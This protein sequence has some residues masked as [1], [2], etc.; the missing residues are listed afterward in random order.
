M[1][2]SIQQYRLIEL[3][4]DRFKQSLRQDAANTTGPV[5]K[6]LDYIHENIF[7]KRLNVNSILSNCNIRNNNFSSHFTHQIGIQPR[8]YIEMTRLA[9]AAV[10]L[11]NECIAIYRI[12]FAVGY[13]YPESFTRA[14]KRVVGFTP[15]RFREF[16]VARSRCAAEVTDREPRGHIRQKTSS[17]QQR[18]RRL[19]DTLADFDGACD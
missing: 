1:N 13:S 10:L 19:I 18:V 3:E 5:V 6:T 8:A 15:Q 16:A 12:A 7:D 2:N 17:S 9:A 11:T 14:F 4:L